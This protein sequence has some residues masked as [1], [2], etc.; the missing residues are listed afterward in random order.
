M[1]PRL[2]SFF[3]LLDGLS[4]SWNARTEKSNRVGIQ[5]PK[6]HEGSPEHLL[7]NLAGGSVGYDL[8][9]MSRVDSLCVRTDNLL[10][11]VRY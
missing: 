1:V 5:L 4:N 7:I 3:W 2:I 8:T 10:E 9:L 11:S 6:D